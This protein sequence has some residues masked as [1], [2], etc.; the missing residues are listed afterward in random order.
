MIGITNINSLGTTNNLQYYKQ[1]KPM[2]LNL[3]SNK[4]QIKNHITNNFD[5]LNLIII[6]N[7]KKFEHFVTCAIYNATIDQN[8][9][10][11]VYITNLANLPLLTISLLYDYEKEQELHLILSGQ[12]R[13][14]ISHEPHKLEEI[15]K[16]FKNNLINLTALE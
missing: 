1:Q 8:T 5:C 14:Y 2:E 16:E 13:I 10:L 11:D 15:I 12:H 6:N 3:D 4:Y 7:S 9:I